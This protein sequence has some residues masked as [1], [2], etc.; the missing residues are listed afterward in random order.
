MIRFAVLAA[1]AICLAGRVVGYSLA[2]FT[3][4]PVEPQKDPRDVRRL[5]PSVRSGFLS[6]TY[7]LSDRLD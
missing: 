2:G 7:L 4:P 3:C 1:L 6:G 5:R